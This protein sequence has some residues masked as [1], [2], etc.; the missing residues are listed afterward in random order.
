MENSLL[1]IFDEIPCTVLTCIAGFLGLNS[2][3]HCKKFSCMSSH[4]YTL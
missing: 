1:A 2:D 3:Q 4:I